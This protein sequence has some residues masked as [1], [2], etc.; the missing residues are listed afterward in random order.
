[1]VDHVMKSAAAPPQL[2]ERINYEVMG[3]NEWQHALSLEAMAGA[4]LKF[5]LD[6]AASGERHRL[7]RRKNPKLAAVPQDGEFQGPHRC[8][9]DAADRPRQQEPGHAR[10]GDLRER[11]ARETAA[12]WRIHVQAIWI[13]M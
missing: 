6:A 5:Y 11:A 8:R 7:A 12:D 13:S 2:S 4:S 10:R 3:A 1:M 9:L